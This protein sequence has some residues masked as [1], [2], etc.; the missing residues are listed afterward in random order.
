MLVRHRVE[1]FGTWKPIYESRQQARAS[2]GLTDLHL[3][4]NGDDL[5]EIFM[6]FEASDLSKARAIAASPVAFELFMSN[7]IQ[8]PVK[9]R[10]EIVLLFG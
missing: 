2:A 5:H 1:D 10:P 7:L 8:W 4:Q 9:H 6:L 3:W